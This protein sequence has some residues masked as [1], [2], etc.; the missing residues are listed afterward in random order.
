MG[1]LEKIES[2]ESAG[3]VFGCL[4]EIIK[5]RGGV[6]GEQNLIRIV[7]GK[8]CDEKDNHFA[9]GALFL[10]LELDGEM[11]KIRE[12]SWKMKLVRWLIR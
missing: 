11:E 8:E 5:R 7:L 6:I 2:D 4:R 10:A 9:K 3:N 1:K 12:P